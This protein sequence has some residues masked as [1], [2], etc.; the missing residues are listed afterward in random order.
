MFR[1]FGRARSS[2]ISPLQCQHLPPAMPNGLGIGRCPGDLLTV[3]LT[4]TNPVTV[5][6]ILSQQQQP[7]LVLQIFVEV[8]PEG[9][10][11]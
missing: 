10:G 8:N 11:V 9:Q 7:L 4:V 6:L 5:F 1:M 2:F 3:F